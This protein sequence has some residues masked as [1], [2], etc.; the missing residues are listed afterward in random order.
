FVD[1]APQRHQRGDRADQDA[2]RREP[3]QSVFDG[4][5]R[6]VEMLDDIEHA[7]RVENLAREIGDGLP[8]VAAQKAC[9]G[10]S[11]DRNIDERAV[12]IDSSNLVP[13]TREIGRH[14]AGSATELEDTAA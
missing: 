12:A 7:D 4:L 6:I 3:A 9:G 14:A 1:S 13:R 11:P 10:S 5:L 2:T 8:Q